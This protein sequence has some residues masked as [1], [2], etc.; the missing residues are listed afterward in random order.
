MKR[1]SGGELALTPAPGL[2]FSGSAALD[3]EGVFAGVVL[4]KPV[5]VAG[6]TITAATAQASLVSADIVREFLKANGVSAASGAPDAKASI[7][8]VKIADP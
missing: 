4:L 5:V 7:V 2:G 8:R 1:G 6:P 3:A